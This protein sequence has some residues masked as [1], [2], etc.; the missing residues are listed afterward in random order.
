[1]LFVSDVVNKKFRKHIRSTHRKNGQIEYHK[2]PW[3]LAKMCLHGI[4]YTQLAINNSFR[5]GMFPCIHC[6]VNATARFQTFDLFETVQP[7]YKLV[8]RV[9]TGPVY[10]KS[11]VGR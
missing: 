3:D 2:C 1:M 6:P 4:F 7:D 5:A 11:K 9:K 10:A 8:S